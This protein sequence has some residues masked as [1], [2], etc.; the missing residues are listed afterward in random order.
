VYLKDISTE[1][2]CYLPGIFRYIHLFNNDFLPVKSCRMCLDISVRIL[3]FGVRCPYVAC[4][5][6][7]W[8][9]ISWNNNIYR[10]YLGW[11][12]I[13]VLCHRYHQAVY[14]LLPRVGVHTWF[15]YWWHIM[16]RILH[17]MTFLFYQSSIYCIKR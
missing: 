3:V 1:I 7:L 15:S 2:I 10:K 12:Y 9:V 14:V 13:N 16:L 6:L 5:V 11:R 17:I 8:P 4:F